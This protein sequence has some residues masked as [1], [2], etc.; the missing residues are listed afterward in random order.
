MAWILGDSHGDFD[1]LKKMSKKAVLSNQSIIV[2][3]DVGIGFP[4]DCVRDFAYLNDEQLTYPPVFP[5]NF[6]FI[7][8]NHDKPSLSRQHPNYLGDYGYIEEA[9]LFYVSGAESY[10]R[11]M[12]IPGI[13]WW[14]DEELSYEELQQM[15]D[16]FEKTK[17]KYVISHDCPKH[18]EHIPFCGFYG[19]GRTGQ[20]LWQCYEMHKPMIHV[21]AHHH[22]T[23]V[24]Q[25]G[26]TKFVCV[27]TNQRYILKGVHLPY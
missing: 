21:F 26:K 4:A 14:D 23:K 6:K 27:G 16:L 9:D 2:A 15:I 1:W 24:T 8:G 7:R 11:D 25:V 17:P 3:G 22:R 5:S 20:A 13:S 19:S 12:R 18:P 10:D